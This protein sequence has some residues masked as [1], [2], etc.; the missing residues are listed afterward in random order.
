MR[1]TLT[2]RRAW[3]LATLGVLLALGGYLLLSNPKDDNGARPRTGLTISTG[4]TDSFRT[5]AGFSIDE[6]PVAAAVHWHGGPIAGVVYF[7]AGPDPKSTDVYRVQGTLAN[8]KRLTHSRVNLGV[9]WMTGRPG[10]IVIASGRA[11]AID[12]IESLEQFQRGSPDPGL[13]GSSPALDS[14]GTLAYEVNSR[15][16]GLDII[17]KPPRGAA[18]RIPHSPGGVA[19]WGPG[20]RLYIA[21]NKRVTASKRRQPFVVAGFGGR[22]P[23]IVPLPGRRVQPIIAV[24]RSG[25]IASSDGDGHLTI[26]PAH[27]APRRLTLPWIPMRWSPDDRRLLVLRAHDAFHGGRHVGLLN[28]KTGAIREIGSVT[29]GTVNVAVWLP[30]DRRR[31]RP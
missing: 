7:T 12:H 21:G 17:V 9:S 23:Q 2:S 22:N 11:G 6:G 28:P 20:H 16:H 27:G 4:R 5:G 13:R 1:K 3:A 31:D 25:D 8:A 19:V 24:S 26:S 15:T 14:D 30:S 10:Q 29:G 18:R